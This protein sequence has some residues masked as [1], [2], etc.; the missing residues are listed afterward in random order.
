M[1]TLHFSP[2]FTGD[3]IKPSG[4]DSH[5]VLIVSRE[6]YESGDGAAGTKGDVRR[7]EEGGLDERSE[8]NSL[9]EDETKSE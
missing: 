2:I 9:E 1:S 6:N 4:P 5:L 7:E 3:D 8:A